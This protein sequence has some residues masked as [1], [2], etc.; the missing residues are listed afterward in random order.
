M[1]FED[2]STEQESRGSIDNKILGELYQHKQQQSLQAYLTGGAS[3]FLSEDRPQSNLNQSMAS[4]QQ[5][6]TH[7]T[8]E[9]D[10]KEEQPGSQK[11][12]IYE[13]QRSYYFGGAT[14]DD[15]TAKNTNASST[16]MVSKQFSESIGGEGTSFDEASSSLLEDASDDALA[17]SK[18]PVVQRGSIGH[19]Q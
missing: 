5:D 10:G 17:A 2:F 14:Q 13:M 11:N 12:D 9:Q 7:A 15:N 18:M 19:C 16:N 8:S 1:L 3:C 4:T 6:S